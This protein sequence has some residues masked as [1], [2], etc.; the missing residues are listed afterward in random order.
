MITI[1]FWAA[2][3]YWFRDDGF[4]DVHC[5]INAAIISLE[6]I[7]TVGYTVTDISFS[8]PIVS[9]RTVDDQPVAF[10]LLYGEMMQS[11]LMNSFC[12]GVVYARLSRALVRLFPASHLD[13]SSLHHFQQEGGNSKSQRRMVFHVPSVRTAQTS[14][15][16]EPRDL[17]LCSEDSQCD[18]WNAISNIAHVFRCRK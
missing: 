16:R 10:I 15:H 8:T 3:F 11:I 6:T 14:A 4:V 2:L 17:L 12:I 5:Y 1:N 7:T 13:A 18:E 9:G